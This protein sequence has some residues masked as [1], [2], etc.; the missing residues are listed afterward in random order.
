MSKTFQIWYSRGEFGKAWFTA[1]NEEHAKQLLKQIDFQNMTP[2][3]LPNFESTIKGGDGWEWSD[4]EE[5]K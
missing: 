3:E 5:M 1:N 2:E 4:L